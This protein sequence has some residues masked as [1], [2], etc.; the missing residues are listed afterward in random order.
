MKSTS[1]RG[2]GA[3]H[4]RERKRWEPIVAAGGVMCARQGPKCIGKPI[5]PDQPWDLGHSDDRTEWTGPECVPC[6]RGAGQANAMAARKTQT[7][8]W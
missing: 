5:Q 3:A 1:A 7:W 8:A 6:N 4:Q 2:Y